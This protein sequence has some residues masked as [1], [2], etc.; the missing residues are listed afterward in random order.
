MYIY[1]YTICHD[2]DFSKVNVIMNLDD[3]L[4]ERLN[5]SRRVITY[6]GICSLN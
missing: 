3:M 5:N 2:T 6:N 4:F 1:I